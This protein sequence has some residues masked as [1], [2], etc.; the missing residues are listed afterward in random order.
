LS[1]S[2]IITS[3]LLENCKGEKMKLRA[4][5]RKALKELKADLVAMGEK[6]EEMIRKS[7]QALVERDKE[8]AEE[9]I[10]MDDIVDEMD[11]SIETKC[12]ELIATQ[13]P[14]AK[15]LRFISTA[16]KIIT[17]VE[18]VGDYAVDVARK[19]IILA[20]LP[21]LKPYVDVP[22]MA[23]LTQ[24]ML[25][26]S[27]VAYQNKDVALAKKIGKMDQEVD[28]LY[29]ITF[30]ELLEYMKKD[31]ENVERAAHLLLVARY[32]ERIGDHITNI[33]ERIIYMVTGRLIQL[34]V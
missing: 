7:L 29:Y 10:N 13:Q 9:V 18:R 25:R 5:F 31:P 21:P 3:I 27:I 32:F 22:K 28:K 11:L 14:M 12:I 24:I 16:L 17:D 8:L 23:E 26:E 33:A 34:N 2:D 4:P 30:D 15:D 1:Q 6:T 19:A 20:P